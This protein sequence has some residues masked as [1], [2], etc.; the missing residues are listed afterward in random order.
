MI[1]GRSELYRGSDFLETTAFAR[2]RG[3]VVCFFLFWPFE[4]RRDGWSSS[5]LSPSSRFGVGWN[6]ADDGVDVNLFVVGRYEETGTAGEGCEAEAE[7]IVDA[8]EWIPL[9]FEKCSTRKG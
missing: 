4:G 8:R 5:N 7:G 6:L 3:F 1:D 2:V 9:D